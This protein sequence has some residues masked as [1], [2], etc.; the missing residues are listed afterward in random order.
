MPD[1]DVPIFDVSVI[2]EL[3]SSVGGDR[4]FVVELIETYLADGAV[5]LDEIE[6]MVAAG[7]AAG[8]VRP[9]HTLK[10]SSATLGVLRLASVAA[11]LERAGRSGSLDSEPGDA[12]ISALR[13]DWQRSADALRSW[14]ADGSTA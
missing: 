14:V 7:D 2:D 10:S 13:H 11:A 12:Q 3:C 9:A 1:V 5:Q 4:A 6:A 8:V